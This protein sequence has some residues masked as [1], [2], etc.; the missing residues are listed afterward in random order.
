MVA[1]INPIDKIYIY[2]KLANLTRIIC[3]CSTDDDVVFEV[4]VESDVVNCCD[5]EHKILFRDIIAV[6]CRR[7]CC[8]IQKQIII[9][10]IK[11]KKVMI[12]IDKPKI[13]AK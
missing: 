4:T 12:K 3:W 1:K 7:R 10:D 9:I 6:F 5:D 13:K 11:Q 2:Y 8:R